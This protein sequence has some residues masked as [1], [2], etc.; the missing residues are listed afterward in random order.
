MSDF[1][2]GTKEMIF[3]KA[4]EMISSIGFENMSMRDL[5]DSVGIKVASMYNHFPGKQEILDCIYDY[6][7]QH[8][9]D[10]RFSMEEAKRIMETGSREEIYKSM[11][12]DF[13]TPDQKKYRR[14]L[15]IT[16]IVIMRIFNDEQANKIFLNKNCS[17]PAV[18]ARGLLEYGISIGRLESFDTDTYVTF[19]IG[20]M[21]FMGIKAYAR[22]DYVVQQLDEEVG[23]HKMLMEFLP[24]K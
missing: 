8:V 17:E 1:L 9:F 3:D 19:M 16:K 24:L 7:C 6:Y 2:S 11:I 4:I 14:M 21:L 10:N 13:V 20:Q 22:P 18:Y 12:Y 15:L 23:I 5:A